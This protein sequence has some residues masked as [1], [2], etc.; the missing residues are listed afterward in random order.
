M[1]TK[2][3][4]Q[5]VLFKFPQ[6]D[7][8]IGK[9]RPAL[10]LKQINSKYGDWLTCMISMKTEQEIINLDE[11]IE[12][13]DEDFPQSGLKSASVIRVSRLAVISAKISIGTIGEISPARLIK[14]KQNLA[15]WIED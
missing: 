14:V 5:I 10:L 11:I 1:V 9:L 13:T 8:T 3:A 15:R 7:L 2:K 12:L 4:G 6:T